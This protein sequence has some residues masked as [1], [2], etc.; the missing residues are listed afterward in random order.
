[1][2]ENPA[3]KDL[4]RDMQPGRL[5]L[6][7]LLGDDTRQLQEIVGADAEVLSRLGVTPELL[8]Q[9]MR[10]LSRAGMGGLGNPVTEGDYS[11]QVD[12]W[13]GWMG[14][15]FKDAK[16]AAKRISRVT[17][18][19]TGETMTWSDLHIHLIEDHGFFQ[20]EG[21]AHRLDPEKL[22]RFLGLAQG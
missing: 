15:P 21:S 18:L 13:M 7:G 16:R 17:K 2:K 19:S 14:C 20:G 6:D 22:I 4:K 8:A 3:E 12:E 1:M 5:I 10:R 11:V 9:T